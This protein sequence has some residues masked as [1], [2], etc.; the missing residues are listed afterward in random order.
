MPPRLLIVL[1]LIC[2]LGLPGTSRSDVDLWPFLEISDRTTTVLYP[3]YVREGKFLMLFPFYYR[4]NEGQDHHLVWPIVKYSEGRLKR[5]LPLWISPKEG[6]YTLFPI[7]RWTPREIL[8]AVPPMYLQ[9]DGG[10][11]L[12]LPLYAKR[13]DKEVMPPSLYRVREEGKPTRIGLWPVSEYTSSPERRGIHILRFLRMDWGREV[14]LLRIWPILSWHREKDARSFWLIPFHHE[15]S[16]K[17]SD[18]SLYPVFAYRSD[19]ESM[20]L[21]LVPFLYSNSPKAFKS[22]LFG[23][24]DLRRREIA[25]TEN[26]RTSFTLL[27]FKAFSFYRRQAVTS[28]TGKLLEHKRR[29]L[30]FSEVLE[31]SGKRSFRIFG[32]RV[33]TRGR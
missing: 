11:R 16:D 28:S 7:F 33:M 32:L 23:I 3:L 12:V 24:F 10:F 30:I 19:E 9:R 1:S 27:G 6:E 31:A 25:G 14:F 8:S 22:W 4:T 21:W 17:H 13:G 18:T 5:F 26:I 20:G 29:L 15:R 2:L